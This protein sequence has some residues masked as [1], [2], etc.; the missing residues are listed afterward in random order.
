MQELLNQLKKL[1]AIAPSDDFRNR[2]FTA[3]IASPQLRRTMATRMIESFSYS[4]ALGLMATVLV[5]AVGGFSYFGQNP[6]SPVVVGSLNAKSL[7][8][9]AD[10]LGGRLGLA[11]A[12]YFT[13]A[14]K[15]VAMALD[16][17][18]KDT[19][20]HLN[21]GILEQEFNRIAIP[22]DSDTGMDEFINNVSL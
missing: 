3:I 12:R 17:L 22:D 21:S 8:S 20:D 19:P 6:F 10:D 7:S 9:E 15:D 1:H 16:A 2:S 5:V 4:L 18:A 13:D 14:A 11:D